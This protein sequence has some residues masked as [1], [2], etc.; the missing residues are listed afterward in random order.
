MF[1]NAGICPILICS[2]SRSLVS[3]ACSLSLAERGLAALR[4]VAVAWSWLLWAAACVPHVAAVLSILVPAVQKPGLGVCESPNFISSESFPCETL[5]WQGAAS[6]LRNNHGFL[7]TS[8]YGL[9][10]DSFPRGCPGRASP[11]H[12]PSWGWEMDARSS[13]RRPC[14]WGV[15]LPGK[16]RTLEGGE[17]SKLLGFGGVFFVASEWENGVQR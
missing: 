10:G 2:V 1:W 7:H 14:T 16:T 5:L 9:T 15:L 11:W 8:P 6:C 12:H 13:C 4:E 3:R 17:H